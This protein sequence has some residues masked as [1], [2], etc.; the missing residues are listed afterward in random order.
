MPTD[1]GVIEQAV[2]G[3]VRRP[4]QQ[5]V[6]A[7]AAAVGPAAGPRCAVCGVP[8]RCVDP[9]RPV[10]VTGIFGTYAF[11]ASVLGLPGGA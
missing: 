1:V 5:V 2:E 8:L 3:L 9:A 6:T 7:W 4:G 11:A 10:T